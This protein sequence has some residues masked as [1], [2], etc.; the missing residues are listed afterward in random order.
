MLGAVEN[1]PSDIDFL[2]SSASEAKAEKMSKSE[3]KILNIIVC[4]IVVSL[5]LLCC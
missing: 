5:S 1:L 2:E 3:E 4:D